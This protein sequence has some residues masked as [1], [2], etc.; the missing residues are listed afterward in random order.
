MAPGYM[1]GP[2]LFGQRLLG[3]CLSLLDQNAERNLPN[4]A[5]PR[6]VPVTSHIL[7]CLWSKQST[8]PRPMSVPWGA[9]SVSPA[10]QGHMAEGGEDSGHAGQPTMCLLHESSSTPG[11]LHGSSFV[12]LLA[13]SVSEGDD[14]EMSFQE[15]E[16]P[17][18]GPNPGCAMYPEPSGALLHSGSKGWSLL[19]PVWMPLLDR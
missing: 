2:H 18:R 13:L 3:A 8:Q 15:L 17:P 4:R 6:G 16:F 12:I 7:M 5:S 10:L 19:S 1:L 11:F 14:E 9:F